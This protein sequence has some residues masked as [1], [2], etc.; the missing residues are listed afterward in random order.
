[1]F[2]I[3]LVIKPSDS[4]PLVYV[5]GLPPPPRFCQA[6]AP[7]WMRR[8]AVAFYEVLLLLG[9]RM[10]AKPSIRGTI[11][12]IRSYLKRAPQCSICFVFRT[13]G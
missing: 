12:G 2:D 11:F 4:T 3:R 6:G 13:S 9:A 8:V 1:M 5:A 10:T 7:L